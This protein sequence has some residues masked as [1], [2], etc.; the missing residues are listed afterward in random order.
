MKKLLIT[1]GIIVLCFSLIFLYATFI[2]PKLFTIN[3]YKIEN[4]KISNNHGLKI[5]HFSDIHYGTSIKES[6]LKSIVNDINETE[7]DIIFFTGDLIDEGKDYDEDIII[8]VL[9]TLEAPL[10]KYFITGNHDVHENINDILLKSGF[11]NLNNDYKILYHEEAFVISG[12]SSYLT[13][14]TEL[15]TKVHSYNQEYENINNLYSILLVHEPDI[16]NNLNMDNY[17]LILAGHSHGGQ[18]RLPFI[19]ELYTKE[20]A[21][22]YY[23]EYY[24]INETDL[25]V[26]NGLGNSVLSIRLFNRPSFNLYRITK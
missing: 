18:V 9:S 24:K 7:P 2:E 10:G 5:V 25:Y 16:I 20:G 23:E 26:S 21:E 14:N 17:D 13:D 4:E 6:E 19:G 3:E 22:T 1:A 12:I 15:S 11:N 8:S